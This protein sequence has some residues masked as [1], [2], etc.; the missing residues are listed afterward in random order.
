MVL[1]LQKLTCP[2]KRSSEGALG[3]SRLKVPFAQWAR[4]LKNQKKA[5]KFT[6]KNNA[7]NIL[8]VNFPSK[9]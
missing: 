3:C 7:S 5:E 9:D 1:L 8:R 2:Q 4:F 6:V